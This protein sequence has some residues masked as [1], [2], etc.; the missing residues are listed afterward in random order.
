METKVKERTAKLQFRT[1]EIESILNTI[2]LG[3]LTLDMEHRIQSEYSKFLEE[4]FQGQELAGLDIFKLFDSS[5]LKGDKA[6]IFRSS[7]TLILGSDIINWNLNRKALPEEVVLN[8]NKILELSWSPMVNSEQIVENLLLVI[9]DVTQLRNLKTSVH[10]HKVKAEMTTQIMLLSFDKFIGYYK[11]AKNLIQDNILSIDNIDNESDS[12][13]IVE[14]VFRNLHTLKGLARLHDLSHLV[15]VLHHT[16]K[17]YVDLRDKSS[18]MLSKESLVQEQNQVNDV[19]NQYNHI[20]TKHSGVESNKVSKYRGF[21][22]SVKELIENEPDNS[23]LAIKLKQAVA[24]T[25]DVTV[26]DILENLKPLTE[27]LSKE[28]NYVKPQVDI[29]HGGVGFDENEQKMFEKVFVQMIQNTFAYSDQAE[30]RIDIESYQNNDNNVIVY[31]DNGAGLDLDTLYKAGIK[32]G[33]ISPGAS[34]NEIADL[35][36]AS[37]ISTKTVVSPISGRGVGMDAVKNE[38]ESQGYS[39]TIVFC[40][41]KNSQGL[42]AFK[43]IMEQLPAKKLKRNTA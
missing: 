5:D 14:T 24:E 2:T 33:L 3:I 12:S 32:K 26:V 9:R 34:Q 18:S 20:A 6:A 41:D 42:R 21:Y 39:I 28:Y 29:K 13:D 25:N 10:K 43:F 35:I 23:K 11:Y 7:I 16:E 27:R 8:D 40:G 17:S 30:I 15:D 22:L 36:F 1:R 4:I 38:L 37:G 31:K 19:L